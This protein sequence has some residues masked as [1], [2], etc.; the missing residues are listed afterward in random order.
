M[1]F[2]ITHMDFPEAIRPK[3]VKS[4]IDKK[5]GV[6]STEQITYKSLL[7]NECIHSKELN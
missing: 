6:K 1:T 2:G 4:S 7:S 3:F 5:D